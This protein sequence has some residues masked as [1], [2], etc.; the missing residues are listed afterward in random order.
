MPPDYRGDH[1]GDCP[2]CGMHLEAVR[3]TGG[4]PSDGL[5]DGA[6]RVTAGRQQA[7]NPFDLERM[8]EMNRFPTRAL[9]HSAVLLR[10]KQPGF[11][12][13]YPCVRAIA[14]ISNRFVGAKHF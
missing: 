8:L 13:M 7:I 6:V 5:P 9:G 14:P 1:P 2:I 4:A 10:A 12:D 11:S 3:G